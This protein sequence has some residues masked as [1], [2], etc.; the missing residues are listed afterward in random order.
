MKR[1]VLLV[2]ALISATGFI[3]SQTQTA[4][5]DSSKFAPYWWHS[6]DMYDN[7]PEI[8]N[9]IVFLGNSITDGAEWFELLGNKKCINR[10]ISADITEGILIRIDAITKL[11]PKKLF[12]MI[13]VN[14]LSRN[15]TPDEIIVNYTKILEQIRNESPRTMVYVQSVL[16]VNPA[17]GMA[18]N[19]TNKT[20][21]IMELN[22]KLS[23]LAS[24]FGYT[25]IDLFTL[26]ADADN[27]LPR[28]YSIDGLHLSYKAYKVWADAIK[29]Y[30]K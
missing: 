1:F 6:K 28:S 24:E 2:A 29:P 3:N 10:G 11:Q 7:L 8:R 19:H 12:I 23:T 25:Y 5:V 9:A 21:E 27:H 15:M 30:I 13:G 4:A 22:G 16:P 26:M 20:P 14:D 17:T 18:K